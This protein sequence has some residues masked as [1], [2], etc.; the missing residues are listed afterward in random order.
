M[1]VQYGTWSKVAEGI[2]TRNATQCRQRFHYYLKQGSVHGD[3]QELFA[4]PGSKVL[5]A[6]LAQKEPSK[7]AHGPRTEALLLRR[8][9]RARLLRRNI[10]HQKSQ[11]HS[12]AGKEGP[13]PQRS[14]NLPSVARKKLLSVQILTGIRKAQKGRPPKHQTT[15]VQPPHLSRSNSVTMES[16]V[17]SN[18]V[19]C[20]DMEDVIMATS[21]SEGSVRSSLNFLQNNMPELEMLTN[22]KSDIRG[23]QTMIGFS[24]SVAEHRNR[25]GSPRTERIESFWREPS[26]PTLPGFDGPSRCS[27]KPLNISLPQRSHLE[28]VPTFRSL[29]LEASRS[30]PAAAAILAYQRATAALPQPLVHS[31][32]SPGLMGISQNW[33][34]KVLPTIPAS[35]RLPAQ[36]SAAE[37]HLPSAYHQSIPGGNRAVTKSV[38]PQPLQ[39]DSHARSL[40]SLSSF[41]NVSNLER[42]LPPPPNGTGYPQQSRRYLF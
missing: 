32:P 40:P 35:P 25:K 31:K 30:D 3:L 39:N 8:R 21:S 7:K 11:D 22:R 9:H 27:A 41:F 15:K 13:H 16:S 18:S 34:P 6:T 37:H 33:S 42:S 28:S 14:S 20:K 36:Y 38:V 23:V 2:A 17:A 26:S 5:D 10:F 1:R 19:S 24:G 12:G 4:N 29:S